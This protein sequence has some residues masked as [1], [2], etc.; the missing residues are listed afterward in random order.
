MCI[1]ISF[2]QQCNVLYI[3]ILPNYSPNKHVQTACIQ[4]IPET[5]VCYR[6]CS[7]FVGVGERKNECRT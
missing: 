3:E 1:D 2:V 7:V 4:C 6:E 5:V